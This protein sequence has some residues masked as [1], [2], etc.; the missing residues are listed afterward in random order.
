MTWRYDLV[1]NNQLNGFLDSLKDIPSH[2]D[3]IIKNAIAYLI[4]LLFALGIILA[5]VG[6]I[7]WATGW[8]ERSGKKTIV[9]GL[10]LVAISLVSGGLGIG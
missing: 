10:V 4:V 5:I 6:A 3:T 9:K 7:K 1:F 2:L 8:D